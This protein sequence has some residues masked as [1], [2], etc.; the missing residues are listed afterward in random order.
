M[1]YAEPI[2]TTP[3]HCSSA[4]V[5]DFD[6]DGIDELVATTTHAVHLFHQDTYQVREKLGEVSALAQELDSLRQQL[7]RA[8]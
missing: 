1:R 7:A 2:T 5:A 3:A 6:G 8:S 4:K